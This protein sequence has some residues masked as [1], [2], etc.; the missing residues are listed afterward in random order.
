MASTTK[1][2]LRRVVATL[3]GAGLTG[4]SGWYAWEH[5]HD[6]SAPIAAVV[7]AGMF[8][9]S[10]QCW[11][12]RH[13]IRALQ[14]LVLGVLAASITL[15]ATLD[16]VASAKDRRIQEKQSENLARVEAQG[17]KTRAEAELAEAQ[18]AADRECASG[19]GPKCRGL[20]QRAEAA[21]QRVSVASAEL[22]RLGATIAEDSLAKRLAAYTGVSEANVQLWQPVMLP[23]WLDLSGLVLLT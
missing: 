20:E 12:D 21:R 1:Y 16:R 18:A 9:Y 23:A 3:T 10:E 22:V 17:A 13:P 5:F 15:F 6:V 11:R 14:F 7:G 19:R 4:L 8:H 2:A